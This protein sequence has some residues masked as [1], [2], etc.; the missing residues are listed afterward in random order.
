VGSEPSS[1]YFVCKIMGR[2]RTRVGSFLFLKVLYEMS[3]CFLLK[4]QSGLLLLKKANG[5]SL[6]E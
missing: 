1:L 4:K 5:Q 6:E 2:R 3:H